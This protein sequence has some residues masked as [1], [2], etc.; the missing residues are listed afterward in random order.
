MS[1]SALRPLTSEPALPDPDAGATAAAPRF[2][3]QAIQ[4]RRSVA[5][6]RLHPPGPRDEEICLIADAASAAPDHGA[7][8]PT[9]LI[10][11]RD[12]RREALADVFEAALVDRD[13]GACRAARRR[14]R[15]KARNGAVLVAI[16]ARITRRHPAVP[17]SEQWISVGAA[18]QNVLLTIEALGYRGMIVSGPPARSR[19]VQEA[20]ALNTGERLVGFVA[21]GT[22][23]ETQKPS[24]PRC[25]RDLMTT[26]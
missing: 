22:P 16:V 21:M 19:V 25:G 5:P 15:D 7:L 17:E 12:E 20:L 13:P 26:W 24:P 14:A 6:R 4:A 11:I 10:R 1:I 23:A 18:L 8:R 9:R 3:V 2:V